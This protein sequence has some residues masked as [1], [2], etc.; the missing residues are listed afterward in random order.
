MRLHARQLLV[1]ALVAPMIGCQE[2][3]ASALLSG[4]T[5]FVSAEVAEKLGTLADLLC[6]FLPW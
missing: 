4:L 2:K 6:S 5:E 1:A 3:V